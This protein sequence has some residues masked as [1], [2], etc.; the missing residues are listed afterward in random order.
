MEIRNSFDVALSPDEAMTVLMDVERIVP[1]LPGA[2]LTEI[3]DDRTFKG[4]VAV[5]LGP[6][7]LRFAGTAQFEEVD[8]AKHSAVVKASG[9]DQQGRGNANATA[10]FSVS[11]EGAGSRVDILTDLKLAG[12]VAQYGRG[13]GMISDLASQIIGQFADNLNAQLSA[14]ATSASNGST[15]AVC[16]ERSAKSVMQTENQPISILPMLA[17][18][19]WNAMKRLFARS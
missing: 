4:K 17:K 6:I 13:S 2:E 5:R 18:A 11:D 16:G 7:A 8:F 12:A 15:S 19:I 1:C 10:Q 14:E 3:V 9:R